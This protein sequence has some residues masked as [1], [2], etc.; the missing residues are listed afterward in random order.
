MKREIYLSVELVVG[1]GPVE[2]VRGHVKGVGHPHKILGSNWRR[3]TIEV[4]RGRRKRKLRLQ[5]LRKFL[6]L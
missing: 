2:E 4:R 6:K 1:V 3:W 5:I